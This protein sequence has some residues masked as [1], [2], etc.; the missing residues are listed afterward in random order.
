M[1][2]GIPSKPRS[3]FIPGNPSTPGRPGTPLSPLSPGSPSRPGIPGFPGN[4]GSPLVPFR[5]STLTLIVSP[6]QKKTKLFYF[7][8]FEKN[9]KFIQEQHY[10]MLEAILKYALLK[11]TLCAAALSMFCIKFFESRQATYK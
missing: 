1:S 10:A 4:P 11:A 7:C 5:R 9:H 2:P 8:C 3:P 6:V